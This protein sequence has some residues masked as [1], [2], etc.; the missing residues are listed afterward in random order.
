MRSC[1]NFLV[2]IAASLF[3]VV[4]V[5]AHSKLLSSNPA[6]GGALAASPDRIE[7]V[8]SVRVQ[9]R[10][11]SITVTG[12]DGA[13]LVMSPLQATS[14]AKTIWVTNDESLPPGDYTVEWR[15]LSA[16]DHVVS[17]DFSFRVLPPAEVTSSFTAPPP[18]PTQ[19]H[20]SMDHSMHGGTTSVNWPQS[21]VRWLA[22][23]AMMILSGGLAFRLLI[24]G[25]PANE[26]EAGDAFDRSSGRIFIVAA[27]T[28]L[29]TS[30]AA[31][32]LQ[33]EMV[34]DSVSAANAFAVISDTGYGPP[35]ILQTAAAAV[36]LALVLTAAAHSGKGRRPWLWAALAA[37][38]LILLSPGM[39]GHARAA[40]GEYAF[41][42]LSDWLHLASAAL[43]VGGL[44]MLVFA[45]PVAISAAG[46]K[47]RT[48]S[49]FVSGF[50]KLAIASV[51]IVTVTGVY[52]SWIHVDGFDTLA[53]KVYGQILI[54]KA[55]ISVLMIVI[56]GVN[57]YL[58]HPR[59]AAGALE[60]DATLARNV[61]IEVGL[62][63]IVLLLA[64][65]LAFLPP[66]R[67][68]SPAGTPMLGAAAQKYTQSNG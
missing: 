37:S 36:G 2:P 42:I 29:A 18:P 17:G 14:D 46:D 38:L 49:G 64:A 67:E 32:F 54:A 40:S 44:V 25:S 4:A 55:S 34:F 19:D 16:D 6:A 45:V 63:I 23:L 5:H 59:I 21:I 66:A 50:N 30:F 31:L 56:G 60:A 11:C 33:T 53:G 28:S 62:A 10:M 65:V 68:H 12:P 8:L 15:A 52:N 51:L 7:L 43:W 58:V 9:P 24:V 3:A 35:W 26:A 47:M 48:L 27:T 41:A 39:T 57:A 20:S 13:R 1:L 61:R 22:Y